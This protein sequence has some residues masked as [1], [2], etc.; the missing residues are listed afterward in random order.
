[1]KKRL[2]E[3]AMRKFGHGIPIVDRI[4]EIEIGVKSVICGMSSPSSSDSL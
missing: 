1:M 3:T 4:L 2:Q